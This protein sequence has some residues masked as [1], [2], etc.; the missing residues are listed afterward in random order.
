MLLVKQMDII[1]TFS[2][3]FF[4]E[5]SRILGNCYIIYTQNDKFHYEFIIQ[6]NQA[7]IRTDTSLFLEEIAEYHHQMHPY[8]QMYYTTDHS[9]S[10]HFEKMHTFKLPISI[11]QVSKLFLNQNYLS[12]L[13]KYLDPTQICIP[14]QII[15]DEYVVL[16]RH[17]ELFLA[18]EY[19]EKMVNVYLDTPKKDI[20]NP[21]YIAKEQNTRNIQDLKI[22]ADEEYQ[23]ISTQFNALLENL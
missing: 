14:V 20:Q 15:D 21:L 16:D 10:L 4:K 9:F 13:R 19:G 7:K 2:D 12:G 1:Q 5:K 23:I 11:L 3:I 18:L 6:E 8:I 22:L 17:H